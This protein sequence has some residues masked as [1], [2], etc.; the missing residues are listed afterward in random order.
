MGLGVQRLKR[1]ALHPL[2]VAAYSDDLDAV[3][4]LQFPSE[5]VAEHSLTLHSPL[6][7]VNRYARVGRS[8]RDIIYGPAAQNLYKNVNPLI[9]DFLSGDTEHLERLKR[10]ISQPEWERCLTLGEAYL[11]QFGTIARD[12]RP[13][14]TWHPAKVTA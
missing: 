5:L 9:A 14:H 4:M 3:V 13:T 11:T 7:T 8:S 2:L 10:G 6:I 1:R 12:G